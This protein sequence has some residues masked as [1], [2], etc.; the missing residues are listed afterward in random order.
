MMTTLDEDEREIREGL[1][2]NGNR[3]SV[4]AKRES[5]EE[6]MSKLLTEAS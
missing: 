1:I 4:A 3:S 5:F 2:S 6:R